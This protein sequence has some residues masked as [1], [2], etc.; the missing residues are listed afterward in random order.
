[1]LSCLYGLWY[2]NKYEMKEVN[3]EYFGN[4]LAPTKLLISTQGSDY[5]DK[6]TKELVCR[7]DK[8]N[9]YI[10][11]CDITQLSTKNP[12]DYNAIILIHT[13]EISNAPKEVFEFLN[14]NTA[15]NRVFALSTSRNGD[16][17]IPKVDGISGAS[18]IADINPQVETILEWLHFI[19]ENNLISK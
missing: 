1:M 6:L 17:K 4:I 2:I 3:Q 9:I 11:K 16:E 12:N 8:K 19:V 18:V 10:D 15:I 7:I 14:R 13:W 5:K